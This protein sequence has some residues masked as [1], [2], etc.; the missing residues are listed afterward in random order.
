Q[1]HQ[2]AV[3]QIR[4]KHVAGL[5]GDQERWLAFSSDG[6]GRYAAGPK[7]RDFTGPDLDSVT[8]IGLVDVANAD[9]GGVAKVNGPSV[10]ERQA[11]ANLHD[12]DHLTGRERSHRDD[13]RALEDSGGTTSDISAIHGDIA[14]HLNVPHG[15]LR[16][17]HR[18]FEGKRTAEQEGD[19]VVSP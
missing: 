18:A 6:L 5:V 14:P 17:Q 13:L 11:Y 1:V 16:L 9:G 19:E 8:V 10:S 4:Q 12:V 15:Q 3:A 7:H 2:F